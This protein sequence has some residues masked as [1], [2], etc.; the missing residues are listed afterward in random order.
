[1][2]LEYLEFFIAVFWW[3]TGGSILKT[4]EIGAR[5]VPLIFLNIFE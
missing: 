5:G 4:V 1:M 3:K 2:D